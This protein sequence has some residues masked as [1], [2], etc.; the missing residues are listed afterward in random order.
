V[1]PDFA[2][3]GIGRLIDEAIAVYRADFRTLAIP[4]A[5][6]LLPASLFVGLAQAAY[7]RTVTRVAATATDPIAMIG[8]VGGAYTIL[9]ALAALNALVSL[10]Y[11]ACVLAA[12]PDL[13]ERRP[14]A[15]GAFLKGGVRR[16]L[17]MLA[18]A[19]LVGI[20][21]FAGFIALIVPGII[22]AVYLSM[23][24]LVA[25]VESATPDTAIT[26]SFR[27]VSGN[28]W[29][30]VGFFFAIGVIIVSLQ[31]AFTS[32]ASI[33]LLL[34]QLSGSSSGTPVPALGWQVLNGL[35]QAIAQTLTLPLANV[36]A[37]LFY[38]DLRARREGMDLLARAQALAPA[39]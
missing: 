2:P 19:L 12:A 11:F 15:L 8:A 16:F 1:K 4:A 33:Q 13:L 18:A 23:S 3:K 9:A 25:G 28:F 38:F 14:V 21:E 26:R 29:R 10:Y 39:A 37:L 27:L 32:V 36:A 30:V 34:Q 17:L 5:C 7:V 35:A 24:Q 6:V 22:A 31:S 20:I